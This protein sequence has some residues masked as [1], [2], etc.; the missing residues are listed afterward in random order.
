MLVLNNVANDD[1]RRLTMTRFANRTARLVIKE[2]EY[3]DRPCVLLI[4]PVGRRRYDFEIV[5]R[6]LDPD[7]YRELIGRCGPPTRA[8]S[9]RWTIS[10]SAGDL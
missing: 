9:R 8:G 2:L 3:R 1:S 5:R 7:R 10:S 4:R 6:S